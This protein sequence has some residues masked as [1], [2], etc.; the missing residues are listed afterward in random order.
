MLVNC[1]RTKPPLPATGSPFVTLERA[2]WARLGGDITLP[3]SEHDLA[4]LRGLD[5]TVS[6]DEAVEVYLPLAQ[7]LNL[8][9]RAAKELG[10]AT[11]AFLGRRSEP[12]PFV[13]GMAGSVAVGKST[14]ARALRALLARLPDRHPVALISTDGF[15]HPNRELEARG[16]MKR[17]GF[18]AS[19]DV[20]RLLAFVS[21]LKSGRTPLVAPQYS[22]LTYDIV[23]GELQTLERPD[24]VILEGLTLLQSG[25]EHPVFVSDFLDFAIY[26]DAEE[27]LLREWYV[28]R[29]LKLRD[30]VFRDPSSYFHRYATLGVEDALREAG[31]IWDEINGLNLREN[32]APTRDR[33]DLILVK[34][35]GHRVERI[36]MRRR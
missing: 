33:A 28:Q 8:H 7:L 16:L 17:K 26:V 18:P 31:R 22:H 5:E 35:E 3:L 15:L 10:A 27:R 25:T 34:G 14:T 19:Y 4:A 29:F 21:D 6:P 20:R 13:I 36:F 30:T 12:I 1:M 32:I 11:R 2:E 24:V 23:P 9:V